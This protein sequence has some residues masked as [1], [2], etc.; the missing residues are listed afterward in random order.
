[1]LSFISG[2][3]VQFA[4]STGEPARVSDLSLSLSGCRVTAVGPARAAG[5]RAAEHVGQTT[6]LARGGSSVFSARTAHRRRGWPPA[7]QHQPAPR[8]A[9]SRALHY[10]RYARQVR[11]VLTPLGRAAREQPNC[12]GAL[13]GQGA[14]MR[15]MRQ[16]FGT[17]KAA[18]RHSE[19]RRGAWGRAR[20]PRHRRPAAQPGGG[21]G[22]RAPLEDRAEACWRSGVTAPR[23]RARAP[24][25]ARRRAGPGGDRIR[26]RASSRPS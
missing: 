17:G 23:E 7:A 21:R 18:A 22:P 4:L 10:C 24:R 11:R 15:A 16:R 13:P 26:E 2:K 19:C 1:M 6:G 25:P 3:L 5:A 8:A 20:G 14:A 9:R 12:E